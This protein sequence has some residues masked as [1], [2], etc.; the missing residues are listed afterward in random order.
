MLPVETR[1]KELSDVPTVEEDDDKDDVTSSIELA[2]RIGNSVLLR[3]ES[4]PDDKDFDGRDQQ[5]V[6]V[7][8]DGEPAKGPTADD[9]DEVLL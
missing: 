9:E 6:E 3:R 5:S 4:A 1:G 2:D 7:D 8:L